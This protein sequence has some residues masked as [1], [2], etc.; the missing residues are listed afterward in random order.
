MTNKLISGINSYLFGG[1][2]QDKLRRNF[3]NLYLD[4]SWFGILN[5]STLAFL[6]VYAARLKASGFEIG[7][8]N[9]I[10]A[11][12]NLIFTLPTGKWLS[13]FPIEKT[14][15]ISAF[16]SR[17]F[18]LFLILLPW[19]FSA[20]NQITAIIVLLVIM[21]IPNTILAVGFSVLFSE[22]V[23]NE[24]RGKVAGIRN[25]LLSLITMVT[26]IICGG[27][28]VNTK[29]PSGYQIVFAMGFMGS[30]LS[31]IHLLWVKPFEVGHSDRNNRNERDLTS[32][33]DRT[34]NGSTKGMLI[35]GMKTAFSF[36]IL[37]GSYGRIILL[38]FVFHLFQYL[39]IPVF[40]LY[41][42][43]TLL[44]SDQE[45]SIGNALFFLTVFLGA[46]RVEGLVSKIGNQKVTAFG[47]IFMGLYPALIA[48]SKYWIPLYYVAS[49]IGGFAWAMVSVSLLNYLLEK[50]PSKDKPSYLAWY[51]LVLNAAI[52]VG[53]LLGPVIGGIVGFA[54]ALI[55]FAVG[56]MV[57]GMSILRWG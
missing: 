56:R 30:I 11:F 6:T 8:I 28:L 14:V 41:S 42:V 49:I 31:S 48:L 15:V 51:N 50:V 39:P 20:S 3:Y 57:A 18:Y 2:S 40:P 4:I 19:L 29:F 17:I 55:I 34:I 44:L 46:L 23:P 54:P 12:V 7:L 9:A 24:W 45:I 5:G 22:A 37:S 33:P 53:A 32:I 13:L 26:S 1:I 21:S 10:P 47:T 38:L 43:N 27:I 52:L 35:T 36:H 25:A 16:S